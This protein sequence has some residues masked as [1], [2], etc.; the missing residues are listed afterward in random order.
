MGPESR[1][2]TEAPTIQYFVP[3][4]GGHRALGSGR[5]GGGG[6]AGGIRFLAAPVPTFWVGEVLN[7][8]SLPTVLAGTVVHALAIA[9]AFV[10][11]S[12]KV[13]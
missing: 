13:G 12:R 7:A 3:G 10:M 9:W 2:A 11:V 1:D 4:R 5:G 8:P 6:A